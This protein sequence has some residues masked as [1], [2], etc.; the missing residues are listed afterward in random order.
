MLTALT[1]DTDLFAKINMVWITFEPSC[2]GGVWFVFAI[3]LVIDY[4]AKL[5]WS[6]KYEELK[7]NRCFEVSDQYQYL[8]NC[9]PTPPLTQH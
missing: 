3:S 9:P 1:S 5:Y 6:K 7:K 2:A 4:K 8:D